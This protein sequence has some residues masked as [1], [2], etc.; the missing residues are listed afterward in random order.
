VN[1]TTTARKNPAP[2]AIERLD[3]DVQ[4]LE[5]AL[6]DAERARDAARTRLASLIEHGET[7]GLAEARTA[8]DLSEARIPDISRVLETAREDAQAAQHRAQRT[9]AAQGYEGIREAVAQ[10]VRR[11]AKLEDCVDALGEA[12]M[13]FRKGM[14]AA[15]ATMRSA[16]VIP[17]PYHLR[18]LYEGFL[19]IRLHIATSG[20]YGRRRTLESQHQ[21][22]LAGRDS[23]RKL[24]AE[25]QTLSLQRARAALRVN[26]Q[27]TEVA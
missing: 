2:R 14:D 12:L 22:E 23:L 3:G 24:A 11:A 17:D 1:E 4:R 25:Y 8:R 27:Q 21:I 19:D 15:D 7:E 13:E 26:G 16:G 9:A 5:R 20:L 18:T 6:S 10:Q